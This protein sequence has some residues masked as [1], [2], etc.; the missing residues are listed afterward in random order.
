MRR[1]PDLAE[2]VPEGLTRSW[3]S[4]AGRGPLP[5]CFSE[6]EASECCQVVRQLIDEYVT[7]EEMSRSAVRSYVD[8]V[9]SSALDLPNFGS[10]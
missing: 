2:G 3:M 7:D 1:I 9:V 6:S 5:C 4:R 10:R 8:Y